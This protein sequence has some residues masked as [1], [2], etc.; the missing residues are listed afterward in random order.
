MKAFLAA[1]AFAVLAAVGANYV[2]NDR[3]QTPSYSA[4]TTEGSR[5]TDP[6][7]NLVGY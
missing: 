6:G 3:F 5:L 7:S 2:L 1:V 4:F